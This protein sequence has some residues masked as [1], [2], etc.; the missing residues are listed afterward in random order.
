M[1]SARLEILLKELEKNRNDPFSRYLVALEY[2]KLGS[3][4]EAFGEFA[5]LVAQHPQYVPTYY[6]YAAALEKAGRLAEAQHVLRLGIDAATKAGDGHA[7]SEMQQAL[8]LI[9]G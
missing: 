8:D 6:Q 5:K 3:S 9:D 2:V 7:R 1:S 4:D